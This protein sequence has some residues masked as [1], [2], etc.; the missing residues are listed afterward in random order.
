MNDLQLRLVKLASIAYDCVKP[1]MNDKFL[2]SVVKQI[3]KSTTSIGANYSEAQASSSYRD[4]NNKIK[5]AQKELKESI[6]WILYL[7]SIKPN[8]FQS[9]IILN[10][11][12]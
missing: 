10:E 1:F 4:F 8:K 5:I 7:R 12:D 11:M 3:I 9:E 2:E 6:Y